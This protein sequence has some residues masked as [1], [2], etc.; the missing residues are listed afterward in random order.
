MCK[1]LRKCIPMIIIVCMIFTTYP[2]NSYAEELTNTTD[3]SESAIETEEP[4][5][6]ETQPSDQPPLVTGEPADNQTVETDVPEVTEAAE[7]LQLLSSADYEANDDYTFIV[8]VKTGKAIQVTTGNNT[9]CVTADANIP[10]NKGNNLSDSSL[11][12]MRKDIANPLYVSFSSKANGWRMLKSESI[13]SQDIIDTGNALKTEVSGWEAFYLENLPDG[14]VA[15]KDGRLNKYLSVTDDNMLMVKA[16]T[17]GSTA[18]RFLV[19]VAKYEPE[20]E[21]NTEVYIEHKATGKLVTVDGTLN[22]GIDVTLST[23][24]VIPDNAKFTAYYGTFS[25]APVVNFESKQY[26]TMWKSDGG[27]VFQINKLTPTG[28]ESVTME[29][30]GD[31]SVAF[32]NNNNYAYI[33]VQNGSMVTPYSGTPSDNEKFIIHTNT[34]PKKVTKIKTLKTEGDSITIGWDAVS[35]TIFSG[36][37]V[38]RADSSGGTYAKVGNETTGTTFTDTGLTFGAT[39]YYTIRTV[40][41]P[42][43]YA[44]S[45][46]HTASTTAG[47]RPGIP[48]ELDIVKEGNNLTLHWE[49]N[50]DATGYQ[51]YRAPS[52]FADYTQIGT[53]SGTEYTDTAPNSD[54]YANYYKI[55][56]VN[57]YGI[58]D[59]SAPISLETK[60]FGSNMIFFS[61][62]DNT[63]A[64]DAEVARI[65][66][67]QKN[68]QFGSER[69][70]LFFKPGDYTDT[71]MMQIGF[72]T[73]IAGLGKTPLETKLKNMETPAYLA[74]N[75]ATCNFW[76][77]AE[78]LSIVDTDNNGDVYYNFKWAVSQ[79]A[80][81]RRMDIGRR[82]TFDWWYGWASGGFAADSI[83]HKAAGSYS[84]QQYYT[85]NSVLEEG[86][87]G[88][89]W[90]GF[91][92]GVNGA[93]NTNWEL[94]A[95][96]NN[97][98]N[99]S[100]TPVIREKP[101]LYSDN[102]EYK[103]FV[104]ALRRDA[105]GVTWSEGNMGTGTSLG[106]DAFYIAKPETDNAATI[107]AAL[108]AG[109]NILLTPGIYY[110]EEPIVVKNAN[111][112]VLGI[113]LAT[114]IPTNNKA[115]MIVNDV[116]GATV[117]GI[118]FDAGDYSDHLLV[119]GEKGSTKSHSDNPTLLAD[120]FFRVG[121]VHGGVASADIALE[122]NSRNVIG[123]HFWI[124]RADHGDGV[125]WNLNKSRNG[126]VVNGNDVTIYGL[127]NEH[128]QE[129][130]A[131]WNG[132]GGR[133]YFYQCET[134]Y[135]PQSQEDYMSHNGTV[136]G[137]AAYKVSN[138]V[139]THYAVGLGIYDVF[140]NTNGASIFIDNA[141]EVP[142]KEGVIVENA[143]TVEIANSS[144]PLV[145]INSIVN[146]TGNGISNG[147]GGKGFARE[148]ILKYQNGVAALKDGT[149]QGTQPAD[150]PTVTPTEPS[151]TPTIEPTATPTIEPTATPTI[152]PT[153]TPTAEPTVTPTITPT[154]EPTATP[155]NEPTATPTI[156]PTATP[157]AEPTVTPT[158]V[159]TITPTPV[160]TGQPATLISG[161]ISSVEYVTLPGVDGKVT[162]KIEMNTNTGVLEVNLS[163]PAEKI[164][165]AINSSKTGKKLV[166]SVPISSDKLVSLLQSPEVIKA[167]IRVNLPD[168]IL[169]SDRVQIA[170]LLLKA[171]ILKAAQ[172]SGK[173]ITITTVDDKGNILYAWTFS[174]T[175]L[176]DSQKTMT[177]VNLQLEISKIE[178]NKQLRK[179]FDKYREE[180][181]KENGLV[182]HFSH[183]GALPA[184]ASVRVNV[185]DMGLKPGE[186]VFLYSLDPTTGKLNTLPSGFSYQVDKDGYLTVNI[187]HCSDYILLPQKAGNSLIIS[188]LGQI[189]VTLPDGTLHLKDNN[190]RETALEV[191]L[192]AT[193]EI[194]KDL[195]DK[196]SSRMARPVSVTFVSSNTKVAVVDNSGK[197]TA[198][199]VGTAKITAKITLYSGKVKEVIITVKIEK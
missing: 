110:A 65:Y 43:P 85:R 20:P 8:S 170:E 124:W 7:T 167:E 115:A 34:A 60:L 27:R 152:A 52:K 53:V 116:D 46:E 38:W 192:P 199:G 197:I 88:V 4:E 45:L 164:E 113:G 103:V 117:A 193:L 47:N 42:S 71:A 29:P 59:A 41:G 1:M 26:K 178:D 70:G 58:S 128:F 144:G 66:N 10:D 21:T 195:K 112:V 15:I 67:I 161:N 9:A 87:Y 97:Y 95:G 30:Q 145:G 89:N 102:G 57:D 185:K 108:Q 129:Y 159:P 40:N 62:S 104:P 198:K 121:G 171:D 156:V 75:N 23:S 54:K 106:L 32:K 168:S 126:L 165:E 94:G 162:I 122:I 180:E 147:I 74:N 69:F 55:Y 186:K 68:A 51:I 155:T 151:I 5:V 177:D 17:A 181:N 22:D 134:P 130:Q 118:I 14:T 174:G 12:Q 100:T 96:S 49:T 140:I 127:F 16:S 44:V 109:K 78:N 77:S 31:G 153:V 133:M 99:I 73:Q 131:L 138:Q 188:L 19:I 114:I 182:L 148:F 191:S 132:N 187:L 90:N 37:E 183:V 24:D 160:P 143:C 137:Y 158:I 91:F 84:Q 56:A 13:N 139:T 25:N 135:D 92:Q 2:I 80:P 166:L 146:G 61:D 179:L 35:N 6:E 18:E 157:T 119:V 3:I 141:I 176:A 101:F 36:Y 142:N 81:L 163:L 184:G 190:D 194:V 50:A 105:S 111:T 11:F 63:A 172:E 82:S 175:D 28:W 79:A 169:T 123:D 72:Y 48:A 189:K 196:T 33:S 154:V 149:A 93:P 125:A 136:K 76:R 173:D 107:N 120:L 39:Y 98:T 150:E 86:F 64:I 83:F